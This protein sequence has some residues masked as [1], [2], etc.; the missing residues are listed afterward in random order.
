MTFIFQLIYVDALVQN[1]FGFLA[2]I[3]YET[4]FMT[5]VLMKGRSKALI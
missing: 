4:L 5:D 1:K 2:N 3:K